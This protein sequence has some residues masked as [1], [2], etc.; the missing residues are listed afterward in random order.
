MGW[1]KGLRAEARYSRCGAMWRC[2]DVGVWM[3]RLYNAGMGLGLGDLG[4][5]GGA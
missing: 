5:G 3:V 2:G 4:G 1:D